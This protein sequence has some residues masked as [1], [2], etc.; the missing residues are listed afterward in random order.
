MTNRRIFL[1]NSLLTG[2][3]LVAIP[4]MLYVMPQ[5]VAP[6]DK[7][8]IGIIGCKGMGFSDLRSF[9]KN[10]ECECIAMADVDQNVLDQRKAETE[11]IQN[12]PVKNIYKDWRRLID[13]KDVDLVIIGTPDH[14]HCIPMVAACQ[15]G[16]DVYVEKPIGTTIAECDVM[17]RAAKRY[18]TVVQVGQWQRSDPHW[19]AAVDYIHAGHLGK[20]RIVRVFA[21]LGWVSSVFVKPD[22]NIP[23]GV[24]YDMWLGPAPLRPFNENRFH[25]NFRWFWDYAGGL[26][27]DWGVHLLDYALYG[28][29]QSTPKSI[30]AMGG[31]FGYPEDACET[32][33]TLH[34]L[35]EFDDFT[36]LWEHGIGIGDGGYGREHGV[37]FIGEK[38]ILVVDRSSWE[39]I[40]GVKNGNP[41]IEK[42]HNKAEKGGGLDNHVRNHLDCIKRRDRNTKANIEIGSHICKFSALGNIAYRIG[43]KLFWDGSH[44]TNDDLANAYL[45]KVYRNPWTLPSI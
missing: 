40:P 11:I 26:M 13:N 45:T 24:D 17:L 27:T 16:K 21:Y 44:F 23:A 34:T 38:G 8:K 6:S 7:I 28:M 15:A 14:W 10:K 20:I 37:A 22:T 39:V 30:M 12:T 4:N 35:F 18:N 43:R 1:K 42:V 41:L 29:N 32:P 25:F 33:D 5:K 36:I 31:K 9:L 19:Q 2:A 3:G